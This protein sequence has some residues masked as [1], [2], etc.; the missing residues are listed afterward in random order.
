MQIQNTYRIHCPCRQRDMVYAA[1]HNGYHVRGAFPPPFGRGRSA[2]PLAKEGTEAGQEM[3]RQ[4]AQ[5]TNL[6]AGK[7][8]QQHAHT[9]VGLH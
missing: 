4:C 7:K 8:R 3:G 1:E 5:L 9:L 6:S 2:Q